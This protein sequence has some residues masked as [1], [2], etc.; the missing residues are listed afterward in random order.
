MEPL[1]P[2]VDKL[3][4]NIDKF[5]TDTKHALV[6][7]LNEDVMVSGRT[8]YL[9]NAIGIY[10]RSVFSAIEK[11]DCSLINFCCYES[12]SDEVDSVLRSACKDC[13]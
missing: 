11:N 10:V 6:N 1:R 8:M 9:N 3:V 5:D 7:I 12:Q 13:R 4:L 2:L